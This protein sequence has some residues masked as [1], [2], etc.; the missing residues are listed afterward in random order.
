[1]IA[2]TLPGVWERQPEA[3][4]DNLKKLHQLTR[5]ALAEMRALLLEL[6]PSSLADRPLGDLIRQLTSAFTARTQLP[7]STS[8]AGSCQL[9]AQVQLA[10]YRIVQEALNNIGKHSQANLAWVNLECDDA[11]AVL[12]I[13]DNGIGFQIGQDP[14]DHLGLQSMR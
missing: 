11:R 13:V 8:A 14:P 5:G 2:E 7:I 6:H 3:A 4:L 1:M 9:P 12:R 10:Y